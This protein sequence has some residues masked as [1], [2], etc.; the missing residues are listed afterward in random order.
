VVDRRELHPE[1]ARLESEV[2]VELLVRNAGGNELYDAT[3][4]TLAVFHRRLDALVPRFCRWSWEAT[5]TVG[6]R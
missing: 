3:P 1:G 2:T 6:R 5:F 4:P